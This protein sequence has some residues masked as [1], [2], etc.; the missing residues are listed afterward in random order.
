MTKKFREESIFLHPFTAEEICSASP[1]AENV[2]HLFD[3]SLIVQMNNKLNLWWQN[4]SAEMFNWKMHGLVYKNA[5]INFCLP[6][7][8]M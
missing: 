3:I 5:D 8:V 4:F 2:Q 1:V 6:V 7:I